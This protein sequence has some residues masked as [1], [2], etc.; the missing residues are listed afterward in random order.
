M[1]E[2]KYLTGMDFGQFRIGSKPRG[3]EDNPLFRERK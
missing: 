3:Q 1:R 2:R